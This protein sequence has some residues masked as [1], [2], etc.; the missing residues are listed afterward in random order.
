MSSKETI[1]DMETFLSMHM[2]I[3]L[4]ELDGVSLPHHPPQVPPLPPNF[5]FALKY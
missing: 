5:D 1:A 2:A 3:Q 4:L